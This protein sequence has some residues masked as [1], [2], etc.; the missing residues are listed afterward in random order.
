MCGGDG[1]PDGDCDCNGNV[2]DECGVCGGDGIAEGECDCDGNVLDECGI[3]GGDGIAEG[4]CDCDGNVL[5]ALGICGG[6][7]VADADNDGICDSA[8]DCIDLAGNGC[9]FGGCMDMTNPG[10]DPIATYDDGSCLIG[11]CVILV[12]CNYDSTADFQLPG[13][14]DFSSCAGCMDDT[15]C[16]YDELATLPNNGCTYN[17]AFVD[18]DGVCNNDA[19][20]DGVCD[21]LEITGCTDPTN[22][23]YNPSATDSDDEACLVPGCL[24]SFACNYDADADYIVVSLCEFTSCIGCTVEDACNYDASATL[25]S[26]ALCTFPISP[27]LDC[28]GIC[29]NDDD[30]DGVCNEQEIGGCMN[31]EALNFNLYATDDDGSCIVLVGGCV[32]PFACNYDPNV[33]FYIPGSCD[34]SCLGMEGTAGMSEGGCTNSFAC[35]YGA[36]GEP[37]QF[38]DAVGEICM[39]GGCNHTSACNYNADAEYNDG[40]CDFTACTSYGCTSINA[41]N[42]NSNATHNNGSCE[43][44]SCYGCTNSTAINFDVNATHNDGTCLIHGCTISVACNYNP[45]AT[46]DNQTCEYITCINLGCTNSSAC[47]YN[48]N[49]SVNDGSCVSALLGFDCNGNCTTDLNN[50]GV[51]DADDVYGCTDVTALNFDDGAT[52]NNGT[53]SYNTFGCTNDMACNFNHN[54][55]EDNGTCDYSS[56][57]GCMNDNACNFNAE[58]THSSECLYVNSFEIVGSSISVID[59]DEVYSYPLTDGSNYIWT[60]IGGEIVAGIGTNEVIVVWSNETGTLTV[61]ETNEN[62][63]EGIEIVLNVGSVSSIVNYTSQFNVYPNPANDNIIVVNDQ[64]ASIVKIYDTTGREVYSEQ[65]LSRTKTIDVSNLANGTYRITADSELG[66]KMQTIV[67]SH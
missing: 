48:S 37:C 51:C 56:C 23:A 52:V 13:A 1:I 33:D 20:S 6:V 9:E 45:I 29:N 44:T 50:N 47:N 15:A 66:R 54:A 8:D 62:G 49:A 41:C 61:K 63:C 43:F 57:Y 17:A 36:Q 26:A 40:S 18:C 28:D 21:E 38:F 14:C 34:F 58:A 39:I 60:V 10:Y 42:F 3:C 2:L 32:I 22:P 30:L 5:D 7:C 24:I 27:F 59:F 67:I 11:G 16:N 64:G 12:A 65:L 35:N 46:S 25:S 53:C 31:L 55:T 4:E 19:D